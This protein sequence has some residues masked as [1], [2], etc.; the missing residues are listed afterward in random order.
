[1][2][3]LEGK[4]KKNVPVRVLCVFCA[5]VH[6]LPLFVTRENWNVL[7]ARRYVWNDDNLSSGK[8]WQYLRQKK[9]VPGLL[10]IFFLFQVKQEHRHD[11]S[12]FP[13]SPFFF[14]TSLLMVRTKV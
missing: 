13:L 2:W 11:S 8:R 1:M 7:H 6:A 3:V 14:H 4:K 10:S 5:R 12:V 9:N